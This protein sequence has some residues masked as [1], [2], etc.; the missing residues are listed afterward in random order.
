MKIKFLCKPIMFFYSTLLFVLCLTSCS[1]SEYVNSI[2]LSCTAVVALDASKMNQE[3]AE[4]TLKT[5]LNIK[6]NFTDCGI[7]FDEKMF[8][9]E[10]VDGNFG[11]CAKVDDA[12][13]LR[14][15]INEMS[16]NGSCTEIKK[17]NGA[18]F[19]D[20][21]GSWAL[22][23][24][25]D[26]LLI[27]GPVPAVSIAETH[28]SISKY[29]K[30][31]ESM[32]IK[33]SPLYAKLDSMQGAVSFV[34]QLQALPEKFCAPLSLEVPKGTDYSKVYVAAD[35]SKDNDIVVVKGRTFSFNK[36][37][38]S[39]IAT[40]R[41]SFREID[42]ASLSIMNKDMLMGFFCDVDGKQFLPMLQSNP[43]L[44]ALLAGV[45]MA[46]DMDQIIRSVNGSLALAFTGMSGQTIDGVVMKA[47]LAD[48][49]WLSDVDYWKQSC[50]QGSRIDD[51]GINAYCYSNGSSTFYFGVSDSLDFYGGANKAQ[52]LG[53]LTAKQDAWAKKVGSVVNGCRMALVLNID[54]TM[55]NN[56]DLQ[57][58]SSKIVPWLKG[59]K[60]IVYMVE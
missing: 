28:R 16:K 44:Q 45:N 15:F 9:F 49:K 55:A 13:D 7:D 29:L 48:K 47:K 42:G 22:G 21:G 25:D 3:Q 24:S 39:Q 26:A 40:T 56:M 23:F 8:I 50:P 19:S 36:S 30:Q 10:T 53:T 31:D 6:G 4:Q 5:I 34:A 27:I 18:S 43:S 17:Q 2:P 46:I 57:N 41:S 11:L 54:A 38:D 51:A 59:V 20:I 52:A 35:I 32:S 58:L 12:G 1:K 60:S 37:I 14:D 33:A